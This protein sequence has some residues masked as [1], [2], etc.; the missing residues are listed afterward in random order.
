MDTIIFKILFIS[1]T[2]KLN[3][4]V[5]TKYNQGDYIKQ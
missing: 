4:W 3:L 5:K 2:Q 1:Y